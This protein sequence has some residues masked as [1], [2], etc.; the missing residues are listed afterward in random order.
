MAE[1]T[2]KEKMM[3]SQS[4][5]RY[6]IHVSYPSDLEGLCFGEGEEMKP[7]IVVESGGSAPPPRRSSRL[8]ATNDLRVLPA[9]PIFIEMKQISKN[10][11]EADIQEKI[12]LVSDHPLAKYALVGAL[13]PEDKLETIH[14][15]R[16]GQVETF[17]LSSTD[18][19]EILSEKENCPLNLTFVRA[20]CKKRK[21]GGEDATSPAASPDPKLRWETDD[22]VMT[23]MGGGLV[24]SSRVD[25]FADNLDSLMNPI[26]IYQVSLPFGTAFVPAKQV[27]PF[28]IYELA[29]PRNKDGP[30][31]FRDDVLWLQLNCGTLSLL[32]ADFFVECF[33]GQ[34]KDSD[35]KS[36]AFNIC[37]GRAFDSPECYMY[38][39]FLCSAKYM[40]ENVSI[41]DM[42]LLFV[43][44]PGGNHCSLLV[45]CHPNLLLNPSDK[46]PRIPCM[47]HLDS[48]KDKC[49]G[50]AAIFSRM[51]IFLQLCLKEHHGV[52]RNV[53]KDVLIGL[54]PP[55]P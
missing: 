36:H 1:A 44:I 14:S 20:T 40:S 17:E 27:K 19:W 48:Y 15:Q 39:V 32:F 34:V 31:L 24:K 28:D 50:S 52:E 55:T 33:L 25:R 30:M 4:C 46:D 22:M 35:K 18:V 8:T 53:T 11:P 13:K 5:D 42:D 23:P 51:R 37:F 10:N 54:C 45:V 49:H 7:V 21:R 9:S 38:D 6:T 29:L 41:F 16:L 26:L 47:L 3:A 2:E 12:A 43:F